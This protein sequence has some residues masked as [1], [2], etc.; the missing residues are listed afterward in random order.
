MLRVGDTLVVWKLDRLARS[1][2][3]LIATADDL[4]RRGIGLVSVTESIDTTTAA[5]RMMMQM[6][7]VFA[8]FEREMIRERTKA[9]LNAARGR[10]QKLGPKYKFRR[11][12]E[13]EIVSMVRTGQKTAAEAARLFG[14]DRATVGRMLQRHG[15]REAEPLHG[16]K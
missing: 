9:G 10:G 11:A 5:G 3:T 13:E 2:K 15:R 4:A 14:V 8:E 16:V 1:L 7:G 6:V 12:Q